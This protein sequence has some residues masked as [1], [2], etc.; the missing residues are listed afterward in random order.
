MSSGSNKNRALSL[1]VILVLLII[2]FLVV[3]GKVIWLETAENDFWEKR[4]E[5]W[6]IS[7]HKVNAR[8]GN[9]YAIDSDTGEQLLLATSLR[10]WDIYLDLGKGKTKTK[11]GKDT[12]DWIVPDSVYKKGIDEMSRKLASMFSAHRGAKTAG[13][14]KEYFNKQ[15]NKKNRYVAVVK[16][17]TDEELEQLK[18]VPILGVSFQKK[19]KKT[20]AKE[21]VYRHSWAMGKEQ[22]YNRV[23]PYG[24]LAR[25]TIGIQAKGETAGCDTCYDGIDGYY[26]EYL[27]GTHG[28]RWERRI[29][30]NQWVPVNKEEEIKVEDGLDI[31]STLDV[32]LQELAETALLKCL[33][34]NAAESG[35]VILMETHT[36]RIKALANFTKQKDG[37]YAQTENIGVG[38][39]FEPGS[40]FKI[41]TAMMLLDKGLADTSSLVPTGVKHFPNTIKD[42]RDVGHA[43]NNN[44]SFRRA[45]EV[46]SN[47]GISSLIYDLYCK[48]KSMRSHLREDL[49]E[50]F[51]YDKLGYDLALHEPLPLIRSTVQVDD[52]LRMSFGYVT[53]MT[54]L[55][56]LTFYNGIANGGKVMK[57]QF[58]EAISQDGKII[59]R[60]DSVVLKEQMCKP[61]TLAKIQDVLKRVV[62][63]GTGRRLRGTAYGIAG[64]SGTAEIGYDKANQI[65]QHRA[66]FVGY[67]PADDP[68][69]SCIVVI[70]KPQK[71]LT[72]GGDLAAP[73]FREL[74]DRVIGGSKVYYPQKN[75]TAKNIMPIM[76]YGNSS[77]YSLLCKN[78]GFVLPSFKKEWIR[79]SLV[80]SIFHSKA[81]EIDKS[82]MPNVKGLTI[83]DAV[84]MLENLGLKV[85][86]KGYGKVVSQ[87]IPGGKYLK[88]GETVM[89]TLSSETKKSAEDK[90]QT[91]ILPKVEETKQ[92]TKKS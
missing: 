27:S 1:S 58:A 77:D 33:D 44:V 46:S 43:P 71:A 38:S 64:K 60:F 74:S 14:Y 66:S 83:R 49:K 23:Y 31:V 30:P 51:I 85:Q 92:E 3:V 56:M 63:F 37:T 36:G 47:V 9:I 87:S 81:Q 90:K 82:I 67:F 62:L 39:R 79:T 6:N 35:T 89:L 84:Y 45:L 20:G 88:T 65:L 50:Y 42:I 11:S 59:Q 12:V 34:S 86:F 69:Y 15:R 32:S 55:Q 17:I 80:D 29:N 8:R 4:A 52:L 78:L 13:E 16:D 61:S 91:Q 70:S 26:T 19:N 25:R 57:P 48:D 54:P 53:A 2:P 28:Y 72:H 22:K 76:S 21:I 40:T 68:Q 5:E 75:Q 18:K 73:V 41:V 10:Y 7:M 24:T